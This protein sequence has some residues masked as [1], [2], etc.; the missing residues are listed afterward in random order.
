MSKRTNV[1]QLPAS[2]ELREMIAKES[3]RRAVRRDF[4]ETHPD[5]FTELRTVADHAGIDDSIIDEWQNMSFDETIRR[6]AALVDELERHLANERTW[7]YAERLYAPLNVQ[8]TPEASDL[9]FVFGSDINAR[10]DTAIE[11]YRAGIAPKIMTT[12]FGANYSKQTVGE[13]RL[14]AEYA[15]AAGVPA[16]TLIVEERSIA[17]PD[18]VK[19]SI[20]MWQEMN[21]Q[22]QRVTMVTSEFHLLRAYV[23]MY[24]FPD[25]DMQIFTAAP[26]PSEDLNAANWIKSETGRRIILNEYTKL[27]MESK[28][29]Q[30]LAEGDSSDAQ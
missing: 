15:I 29:D 16:E 25:W 7:G 22:P 20:D 13:G 23:D 3:P 11:L 18:N 4:L 19:R 30:V 14:Q 17:T 10:I 12:G 8:I 27:I 6:G 26:A 21:W 5:I 9:I 1:T 28:I 2:A 24:K